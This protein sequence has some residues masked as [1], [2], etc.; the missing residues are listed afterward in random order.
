MTDLEN[1]LSKVT[2]QREEL[3]AV[4]QTLNDTLRTTRTPFPLSDLDQLASRADSAISIS[5]DECIK[6]TQT[7][8]TAFVPCES[9]DC[10]Q[11]N[12]RRVGASI[13]QACQQQGLPSN[14]AKFKRE[15]EH[16]DWMTANDVTRWSV[17]QT[18]D[19][20]RLNKLL[21]DFTQLQQDLRSEKSKVCT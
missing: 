6:A 4:T 3:Q 19:V 14:L 21:G 15:M 16:V 12:L 20:N 2:S 1:S 7:I 17:E 9:C 13:V 5:R 10:V 8:E 11:K 18:T